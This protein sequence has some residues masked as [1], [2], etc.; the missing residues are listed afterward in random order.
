M[1]LHL[2]LRTLGLGLRLGFRGSRFG[3]VRLRCL[4]RLRL[5]RLGFKH[6]WT[7]KYVEYCPFGLYLGVLG[8]YLTYFGGFKHITEAIEFLALGT[9]SPL[10]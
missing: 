3:E 4:G 7:P 1:G 8:H 10:S 5:K 6:T 2:R 9:Q